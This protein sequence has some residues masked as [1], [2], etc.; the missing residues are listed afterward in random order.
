MSHSVV[1]A[2]LICHVLNISVIAASPSRSY[3]ALHKAFPFQL[4]MIQVLEETKY[5]TISLPLPS[6]ESIKR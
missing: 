5:I 2:V 6:L 3:W 4:A 1:K